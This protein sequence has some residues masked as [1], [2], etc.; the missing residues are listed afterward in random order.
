M[1][2]A[3]TTSDEGIQI[4]LNG[5]AVHYKIQTASGRRT[6]HRR[7]RFGTSVNLVILNAVYSWMWN[8]Y[9]SPDPGVD[10]FLHQDHISHSSEQHQQGAPHIG[11]RDLE[12]HGESTMDMHRV[13]EGPQC[14]LYSLI[15]KPEIK[16]GNNIVVYYAG[17]GVSYNCMKHFL[18]P[19]CN[20]KIL[21]HQ[22]CQ[23]MKKTLGNQGFSGVFAI[24]LVHVLRL[25]NWKKEMTYVE[26]THLL[27]QSYLQMPVIAGVYRF[28]CLW[29]ARKA[30]ALEDTMGVLVMCVA[31]L[32]ICAQ[33]EPA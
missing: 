20:T 32:V 14:V 13:M 3:T 22:N 8:A 4:V 27:N 24:T 33:S 28:K 11:G 6:T 23:V 5:H 21:S 31:A 1:V 15:I 18:K 12:V 2:H 30:P 17:H 25:D 7:E 16:Q 9:G 26:L 19:E 10:M 29:Y